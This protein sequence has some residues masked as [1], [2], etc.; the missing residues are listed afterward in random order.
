VTA[1]LCFPGISGESTE[2]IIAA[3]RRIY[4]KLTFACYRMD[5][6]EPTGRFEDV[7]RLC[8]GSVYASDRK[9]VHAMIEQTFERLVLPHRNTLY[10]Y[11]LAF[12]NQADEAED[13]VQETMLRA[14]RS[15]SSYRA[16]GEIR[17]WLFAILR[18]CFISV[19]RSQ[20]TAVL[21]LSLDT[22]PNPEL[23]LSQEP[24][25]ERRVLSTLEHEA[26]LRA[27]AALSPGLRNVL[28]LSDMCGL[29]Y[30]EVGERLG[31]PINTVRS[32]LFYARDRVR[33]AL[34]SWRPYAQ[35]RTLLFK[36]PEQKR[37]RQTPKRHRCSTA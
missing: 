11:A 23:A 4:Q 32:R 31:L 5:G 35:K 8:L 15:F 22:L 19:Y 26:I 36:T 18:N 6:S 9:L 1:S 33:R 30:Q 16:D 37:Q 29:S 14:L 2:K 7:A 28:V 20:N 25:P 34:F 13:L 17:A 21:Q 24:G 12:T 3:A 27:V 10:H